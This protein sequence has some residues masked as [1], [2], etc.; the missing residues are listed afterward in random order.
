[1]G[2]SVHTLC[3]KGQVIAVF[4]MTPLLGRSYPEP[5]FNVIERPRRFMKPF[6]LTLAKKS[7]PVKTIS[8]EKVLKEIDIVHYP[9]RLVV[10]IES[11]LP[12]R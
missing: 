6:I 4:A 9:E 8:W 3:V 10:W 5:N 7:P 1:M 11:S 12:S 2:H